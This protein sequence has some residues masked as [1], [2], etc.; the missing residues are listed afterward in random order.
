VIDAS[1]STI[2]LALLLTDEQL[3]SLEEGA[4]DGEIAGGRRPGKLNVASPQPAARHGERARMP[5]PPTGD[6][7]WMA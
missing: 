5:R 3:D 6:R 2:T 7:V 4:G 1:P